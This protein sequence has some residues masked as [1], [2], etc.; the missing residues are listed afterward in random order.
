VLDYL[1][2]LQWDG[3]PRLDR[4]LVTYAGAEDTPLAHRCRS[5]SS[6]CALCRRSARVANFGWRQL[7]AFDALGELVNVCPFSAVGRFARSPLNVCGFLIIGVVQFGSKVCAAT[8]PVS[9]TALAGH[10]P[11]HHVVDEVAFLRRQPA[12]LLAHDL[13]RHLVEGRPLGVVEAA[14][15]GRGVP[16]PAKCCVVDLLQLRACA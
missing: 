4:W 3:A 11:A 13:A 15:G 10:T 7:A 9:P 2:A 16:A 8:W 5:V 6:R 14:V 1:N 12:V